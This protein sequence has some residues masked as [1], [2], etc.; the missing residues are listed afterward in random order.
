MHILYKFIITQIHLMKYIRGGCVKESSI[1][2][3]LGHGNND[4]T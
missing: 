2:L 4:F 1:T 3:D